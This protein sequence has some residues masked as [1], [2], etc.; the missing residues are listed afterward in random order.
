MQRRNVRRGT[1]H[2]PVAVQPSGLGDRG[3]VTAEFA[4]VVPA[5]L[6]LLGCCLGGFQLAT[7]HAR[8]QDAAA[9]VAR[10]A[11]RGE[12]VSVGDIVP[13]AAVSTHRSGNLLCARAEHDG[14][15]FGGLLGAIPLSATSCTLVEVG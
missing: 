4:A 1:R 12:G 6:L 7:Q 13:G 14:S 15:V 10:S 11:A 5:V 8:L 9:T 2:G 3:S